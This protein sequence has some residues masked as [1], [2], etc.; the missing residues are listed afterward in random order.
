M[1]D[2]PSPYPPDDAAPPGTGT[3][4]KLLIDGHYYSD[5]SP[6]PALLL[7]GVYE[8]WQAATGLTAAR[9]G[10]TSSAW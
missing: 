3:L 2:R 4:D 9:S 5:K 6:V 10:P 8:V 1:A 7:A